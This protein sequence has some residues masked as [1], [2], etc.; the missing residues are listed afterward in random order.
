MCAVLGP[1]VEEGYKNTWMLLKEGSEE[2]VKCHKTK[3]DLWETEGHRLIRIVFHMCFKKRVSMI[4]VILACVR[5]KRK[6][7]LRSF[8]FH[9][10][11]LR[12]KCFWNKTAGIFDFMNTCVT[13]SSGYYRTERDKGTQYELFYKKMD[14]MEY[15]H[16]TLFRPF[17]PLMKV[18]S[19]TV[20]ISR[21]IINIIVPLAGRTEAFAQFMQNFR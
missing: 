7:I 11:V 15:R 14:G 2:L 6:L 17:G 19:E 21:S 1:N 20:D 13:Y 10:I 3:C 16:V 8:I 9:F 5:K 4:C 18:K 12:K